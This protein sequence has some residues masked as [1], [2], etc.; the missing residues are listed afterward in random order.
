MRFERDLFAEA[1]GPRDHWPQ[2]EEAVSGK[3]NY[4]VFYNT[5]NTFKFVV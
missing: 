4:A 1:P 3:R 2:C 5:C